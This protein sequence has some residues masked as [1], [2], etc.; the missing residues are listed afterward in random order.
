MLWRRRGAAGAWRSGRQGASAADVADA[1]VGLRF[2]SGHCRG[3]LG[4]CFASRT[5]ELY[6]ENKKA[7]AAATRQLC[8][9]A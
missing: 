5:E 8:T 6:C 4:S 9:S 1:G 2:R 3:L 7:A